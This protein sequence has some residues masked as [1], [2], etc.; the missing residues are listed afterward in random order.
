V[1]WAF[2]VFMPHTAASA[3]PILRASL[4]SRPQSTVPRAHAE[5][6]R[7]RAGRLEARLLPCVTGRRRPAGAKVAVRLAKAPELESVPGL[8]THDERSDEGTLTTD[9]IIEGFKSPAP[10]RPLGRVPPLGPSVGSSSQPIPTHATQ[11]HR[12]MYLAD[13]ADRRAR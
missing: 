4:S 12:A 11:W 10:A 7:A 1:S 8:L 3:G 9:E 2:H 13:G 6:E 5:H